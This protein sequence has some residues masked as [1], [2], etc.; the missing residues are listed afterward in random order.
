MEF[1]IGVSA[2][3]SPS[4]KRRSR[5]RKHMEAAAAAAA[6]TTDGVSASATSD[7]ASTTTT[8]TTSTGAPTTSSSVASHLSS[9]S[10]S[11]SGNATKKPGKIKDMADMLQRRHEKIESQ[12]MHLKL[13][14]E[15]M[16]KR[17]ARAEEAAASAKA[18]EPPPSK[19]AKTQNE[20]T[21]TLA[22]PG[23]GPIGVPLSRRQKKLNRKLA[24]MSTSV[25]PTSTGA[26]TETE[27][28]STLNS[29]QV[30]EL[31]KNLEKE[32]ANKGVTGKHIGGDIDDVSSSEKDKDENDDDN[33]ED[34]EDNDD[35]DKSE[36]KVTLKVE[37]SSTT[38]ADS[39]STTTTTSKRVPPPI[40]SKLEN[41]TSLDVA[42]LSH[43]AQQQ[44]QSVSLAA[45]SLRHHVPG[46]YFGSSRSD[47]HDFACYRCHERGHFA[48]NCPN[49]DIISPCAICASLTHEWNNCTISQCFLCGSTTHSFTACTDRDDMLSTIS[50]TGRVGGYGRVWVMDKGPRR[51]T[52][53]LM[54]QSWHSRGHVKSKAFYDERDS[55]PTAEVFIETCCS[56]CGL[57]RQQQQQQQQQK[58][59]GE[60][61]TTIN[62]VSSSSSTS[63]VKADESILSSTNGTCVCCEP[64]G[65]SSVD[66]L[67][68]ECAACGERGHAF[69]RKRVVSGLERRKR[70]IEA[71]ERDAKR[72]REEAEAEADEDDDDGSAAATSSG[73]GKKGT[74]SLPRPILIPL[75]HLYNGGCIEEVS[76]LN[77]VAAVLG[78]NGEKQE[79]QDEEEDEE[80]EEE[81]NDKKKKKKQKKKMDELEDIGN[82]VEHEDEENDET[83]GSCF[84]CGGSGH[85]GSRCK[86]SRLEA[87]G[88]VGP[89]MDTEL[90][91]N[92]YYNVSVGGGGGSGNYGGS[93]GGGGG[94]YGGGGLSYADA[95]ERDRVRERGRPS[96]WVNFGNDDSGQH[97][98]Q[99][100]NGH[101]QPSYS[102]RLHQAPPPPLPPVNPAQRHQRIQSL[103]TDF[104]K[105]W[106]DRSVLQY[107]QSQ[108]PFPVSVSVSQQQQQYNQYNPQNQQQQFSAPPR[109][110]IQ[111]TWDQPYDRQG[112][113][114]SGSGSHFNPTHIANPF[115]QYQQQSP[116]IEFNEGGGGG[117]GGG[118]AAR[119]A[120]KNRWGK[121]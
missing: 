3:V 102:S 46:R 39:T 30:D 116:Y 18:I 71:K 95:R 9:S 34:D 90:R 115:L 6:A 24:L 33:D 48:M 112:G 121:D 58:Q 64:G 44:Q 62:N 53:S 26:A 63:M 89:H 80:E 119:K 65:T 40:L 108:N 96:E 97:H 118:P 57:D 29:A 114:T 59:V 101:S 82:E 27:S 81:K 47:M 93:Y 4:K 31:N 91:G 21:A 45:V 74:T 86:S 117:G 52:P 25:L 109:V 73:G 35:D 43:Q 10:S 79:K 19:R 22:P 75:R 110:V 83:W 32:D 68:I 8:T 56:I 72:M 7:A 78:G 12:M 69:C 5:K 111:R 1:S 105:Q 17:A 54:P 85:S 67:S 87:F 51:A 42:S 28:L 104:E 120:K 103:V 61:N 88:S 76:I 98:Q 37:T 16:K 92:E 106:R 38:L 55:L 13:E 94:G 77:E 23:T 84:N 14:L 70:A 50:K 2:P 113:A 66:L 41:V 20:T 60:G 49:K 99:G 15:S 107:P 36:K 11:K 100:R